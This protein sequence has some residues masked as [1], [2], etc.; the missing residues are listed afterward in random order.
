[1]IDA[2]VSAAFATT[3]FL[4]GNKTTFARRDEEVIAI[5]DIKSAG[6][7]SVS[8]AHSLARA[9][10][11]VRKASYLMSGPPRLAARRRVRAGTPHAATAGTRAFALSKRTGA[12]MATTDSTKQNVSPSTKDTIDRKLDELKV[13]KTESGKDETTKPDTEGSNSS[14]K[15]LD[16]END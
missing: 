1:M 12:D 13:T 5:V 15:N 14:S 16:E 9:R 2:S 8:K 7:T 11:S 6:C 10:P 3:T 4:V